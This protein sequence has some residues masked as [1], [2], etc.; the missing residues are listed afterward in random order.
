MKFKPLFLV[1]AVV[2][3][4]IISLQVDRTWGRPHKRPSAPDQQSLVDRGRKLVTIGGCDDCHSPKVFGPNGPEV[5]M[6]KPLSGAPADGPLPTIPRG[7]LGPRSWG[8]LVTN[9]LTTWAGPWGVS[10]TRNLTPDTATGLGSWTDQMFIKTLRTGKHM[11]EGRPLLPPMPWKAIGQLSDSDLV[12]MF[13]YLR[14]L[15]PISNPVRDP[16]PPSPGSYG[17]ET[18]GGGK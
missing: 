8:A 3:V 7:V 11:G 4:A 10:F 18:G 17:D 14:S 2:T 15:K 13:A 16:L 5:D 12:A 9:D 1:L 6:T